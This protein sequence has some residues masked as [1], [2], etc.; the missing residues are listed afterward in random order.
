MQQ[1]VYEKDYA[2]PFFPLVDI[3]AVVNG[4][5]HVRTTALWFLRVRSEAM[6]S[7]ES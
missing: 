2:F 6:I 1:Q 4:L 3:A 5:D 7:I